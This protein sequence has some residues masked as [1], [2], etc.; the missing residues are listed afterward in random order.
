MQFAMSQFS[1]IYYA[2]GAVGAAYNEQIRKAL[3]AYQVPLASIAPANEPATVL[4]QTAKCA[5]RDDSSKLAQIKCRTLVINGRQDGLITPAAA[6]IVQKGIA[7]SE[8]L[9][10]DRCGHFPFAEQPT[11][12]TQAVLKFASAR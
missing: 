5:T 8:I 1:E 11:A 6:Q 12:L 7:N 2:D 3:S 4:I 10:L 9:L